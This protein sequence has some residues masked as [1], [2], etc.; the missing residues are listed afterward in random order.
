MPRMRK[1]LLLLS[2][3]VILCFCCPGTAQADPVTL[4]LQLDGNRN[5]LGASSFRFVLTGP[6]VFGQVTYT[7][8]V[9]VVSINSDQSRTIS[10]TFTISF[11][12]AG[13][14]TGTSTGIIGAPSLDPATQLVLSSLNRTLTIT[15][16]TGLFAGATGTL[17]YTGTDLRLNIDVAQVRVNLTGT[18]SAPGLTAVPEPATLLLLGTGLTGLAAG[19]HRRRSAAGRKGENPDELR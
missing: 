3:L 2:P 15:G 12:S 16:G 4:S 19:M 6:S 7:D 10:G 13:S 9:T 11:G 17:S 8:N 1:T 14:V 18:I 5:V